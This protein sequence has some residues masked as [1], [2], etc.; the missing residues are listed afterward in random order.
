[1][2]HHLENLLIKDGVYERIENSEAFFGAEG[3]DVAPMESRAV[4]A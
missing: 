3:R 4:F 2:Q 1:M